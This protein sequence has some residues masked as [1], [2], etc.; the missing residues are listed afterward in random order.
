MGDNTLDISYTI[1]KKRHDSITVGQCDFKVDN[2]S[3]SSNSLNTKFIFNKR[4][5]ERE[6]ENKKKKRGRV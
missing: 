5:R 1:A 2:D 6:R 3:W 4:E